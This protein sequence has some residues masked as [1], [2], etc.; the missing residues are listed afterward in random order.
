MRFLR[1]GDMIPPSLTAEGIFHVQLHVRVRRHDDHAR[2]RAV[3]TRQGRATRADRRCDHAVCLVFID[4]DPELHR[5][6]GRPV[7]DVR[8]RSGGSGRFRRLGVEVASFL[9]G[10]G[11][12][13]SIVDRG[14]PR[15]GFHEDETD[16]FRLL[17]RA[18]HDGLRHHDRNCCRRLFGLAGASSRRP[19][20]R[21]G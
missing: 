19:G 3:R 7:A 15:H 17:H 18:E 9:A 10:L 11:Q 8:D 12:C 2:D 14:Q 13:A 4:P 6:C 21:I 5:L 16:G 20:Y 1:F